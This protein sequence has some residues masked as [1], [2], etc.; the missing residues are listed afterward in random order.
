VAGEPNVG[1]DAN[2]G[3]SDEPVATIQKGIDLAVA[4]GVPTSVYVAAKTSG[5]KYSDSFTVVEGV[6]LYGAY[7]C[8]AQPCSWNRDV[9]DQNFVTVITG[10]GYRGVVI[11]D[12]ITRATVID[13]FQICSRPSCS[14][15]TLKPWRGLAALRVMA[16]SRSEDPAD[17]RIDEARR[18]GA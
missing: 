5:G 15:R 14:A 7:D 3:T 17:V 13:G 1:D 12:A 6:S 4:L 2:P 10:T 18:D 16:F 8:K 9:D 11:G